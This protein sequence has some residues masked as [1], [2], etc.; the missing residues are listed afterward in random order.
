MGKALRKGPRGGGRELDAIISH[1]ADADRGHLGAVGW[2]A[3][4]W[5]TT[6]E[7]KVA[8]RAIIDAL[9]A[10]ARGEIAPTGPR[11]GTRWPVRFFVR[12]VAWHTISHAWEI[13]RRA[14]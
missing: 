1:V 4:S 3:G 10:S 11:G 7:L 12:R 14:Q 8:R 13:E 5:T 6:A 2:K 9:R